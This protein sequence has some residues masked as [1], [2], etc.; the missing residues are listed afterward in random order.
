MKPKPKAPPFLEPHIERLAQNLTRAS[1]LVQ[2]YNYVG[3]KGKG[4]KSVHKADLLRAAVVFIHA[5]LEDFLRSLSA[6]YLPQADSKVLDDVPLKGIT[7][8]G[9]PVKFLLGSLAVH[10]GKSV[11]QLIGESVRDYLERSNY[12]NTTEIAGL[13]LNI[14]IS[15][16]EVNETFP[17]LEKMMSR[18][19]Q[20][21]HRADRTETKG[22]GKQYAKSIRAAEVE[23]W[24]DATRVF[25]SRVLYQIYLKETNS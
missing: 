18:R 15:V 16:T 20:I 2:I 24:I 14:G 22:K 1:N 23:K 6:I 8:A 9:R 10:R 25:M 13:L 17:Q 11:D 5:S 7:D 19:H 4:R 12:N 3:G 21:V